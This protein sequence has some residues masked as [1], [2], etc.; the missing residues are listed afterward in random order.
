MNKTIDNRDLLIF[1]VNSTLPLP[2]RFDQPM[3]ADCLVELP[4]KREK[5]RQA[6]KLAAQPAKDYLPSAQEVVIELEPSA[7]KLEQLEA[8]LRPL[9]EEI[10]EFRP[11]R[12]FI[13]RDD[14]GALAKQQILAPLADELM[15]KALTLTSL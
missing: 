13:L 6:Y 8:C 15:D 1:F 7:N 14:L 12:V 9:R 3:P 2:D 5:L 11:S 4:T 10:E